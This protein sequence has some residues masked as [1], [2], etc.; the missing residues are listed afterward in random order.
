[1][2]PAAIALVVIGLAG[3]Q[4]GFVG[5]T[6]GGARGSRRGVE[7]G[8]CTAL[9]VALLP[10]LKVFEISGCMH[11]H[12]AI[13]PAQASLALPRAGVR[14]FFSQLKC[15]LLCIRAGVSRPFGAHR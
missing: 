8:F 5:I 7:S 4:V 9:A 2:R 6:A 1:M 11:F 3:A 14:S 13:G 12:Q 10:A 15:C